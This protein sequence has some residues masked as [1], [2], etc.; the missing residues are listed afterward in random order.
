MLAGRPPFEGE[1]ALAI[2]VQHLRTEPVRLE[3]QRP[4]LPEGLCRIVHKLLAKNKKERYQ[5]PVDVLRELRGLR[6]EGLEDSWPSDLLI[7]DTGDVVATSAAR[8]AATQQL[9]RVMHLQ[10]KRSNRRRAIATLLLLAIVAFPAGAA[11]AWFTRPQSVLKFSPADL[12]QVKRMDTVEEQW[13][14][15]TIATTNNEQAWQAVS[16]YFPPEESASNL[17]YSRMAKKGL[18]AYYL[19]NRQYE[20]ALSLYRQLA[21][22]EETEGQ[23]RTQGLAGEALVYDRQQR[24]AEVQQRLAQ[25]LPHVSQLDDFLRSEI[26]KLAQKY[27][28]SLPMR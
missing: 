17:R 20:Q 6:V 8:T 25:V 26:E 24:P 3:P 12:P 5:Q 15:A 19:E 14:Y 1:T 10:P 22:V 18:A 13:F 7:T 2:A 11:I 27:R 28:V 4:D 9:N 16:E 23:F 21:N